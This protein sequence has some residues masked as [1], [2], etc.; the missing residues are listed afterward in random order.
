MLLVSRVVVVPPRVLH[1]VQG[2]STVNSVSEVR[3]SHTFVSQGDSFPVRPSRPRAP[4]LFQGHSAEA[5][6]LEV[7]LGELHSVGSLKV[8][9]TVLLGDFPVSVQE[10]R[11]TVG[12]EPHGMQHF[13]HSSFNP[14]E[15]SVSIHVFLQLGSVHL[16]ESQSWSSRLQ[17]SFELLAVTCISKVTRLLVVV[18]SNHHDHICVGHSLQHRFRNSDFSI[19]LVSLLVVLAGNDG[20]G[21]SL[22][23]ESRL[24]VGLG[25]GNHLVFDEVDVG[26]WDLSAINVGEVDVES[27]R[28]PVRLLLMHS[29]VDLA[30]I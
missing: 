7:V 18:S 4:V 25:S 15:P 21:Q 10:L 24:E 3:G 9:L 27:Y 11:E 28:L 14:N 30:V 26:L 19:A 2:E 17:L 22:H 6:A 5:R 8:V 12:R 1:Q 23:Q 13:V 20:R 29:F 16:E